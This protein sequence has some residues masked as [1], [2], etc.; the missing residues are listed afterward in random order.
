MFLLDCLKDFRSMMS[1]IF[2]LGAPGN[3]GT[4]SAFHTSFKP[5]WPGQSHNHMGLFLHDLNEPCTAK[6]S[7]FATPPPNA[8][9]QEWTRQAILASIKFHGGGVYCSSGRGQ[10]LY[11]VAVGVFHVLPF[12]PSS[13]FPAVAVFLVFKKLHKLRISEGGMQFV[14][15]GFQSQCAVFLNS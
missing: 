10:A 9:G 7:H 12:R 15:W 13:M 4:L 3:A 8:V 14:Q 6:T 2:S 1:S 11:L 5:S